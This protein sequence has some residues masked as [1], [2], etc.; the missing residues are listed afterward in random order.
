MDKD[1][2]EKISVR[3][4]PHNYDMVYDIAQTCFEGNYTEALD[5][6]LVMFRLYTK[7]APTI[8]Y[9]QAKAR[10]DRGDRSSEIVRAVH[11]FELMNLIQYFAQ[12]TEVE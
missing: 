1:N 2:K 10:Y 4:N 7:Y 6:I 12:K 9:L 3:L 8:K 5:S 11:R